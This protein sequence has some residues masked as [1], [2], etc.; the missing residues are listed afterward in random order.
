MDA[1]SQLGYCGIEPLRRTLTLKKSSGQRSFPSIV[2]IQRRNDVVRAVATEPKPSDTKVVNGSS[3]SPSVKPING[4]SKSALPKP[5]NG[6]ST[7]N[8]G[9][10]IGCFVVN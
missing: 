5:I 9:L 4:S 3:K 6:S 10:I 1:A 2:R 7:V 8:Y